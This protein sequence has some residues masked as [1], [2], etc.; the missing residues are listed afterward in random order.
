MKQQLNESLR[1]EFKSRDHLSQ[2]VIEN[3]KTK[4]IARGL[5]C[6]E[7]LGED[8]GR[9]GCISGTP[10]L[11]SINITFTFPNRVARD[12]FLKTLGLGN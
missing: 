1:Q 5:S 6:T 9:S 3:A 8:L 12:L 4:C 7:K 10:G 11:I 2:V